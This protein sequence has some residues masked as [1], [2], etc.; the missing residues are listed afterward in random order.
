LVTDATA[1][2]GLGDGEFRLGAIPVDVVEGVAR[3]QGTS[4]I[5]GSTA[6]MDQLF[7]VAAGIG[8]DR[9]AA[10][11]AAVRLTS[12]TPTR[13]LGLHG[14]GSLRAGAA[15]NLVVLEQNL[16]VSAVMTHGDWQMDR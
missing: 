3:V 6:T 1:A 16:Q 12:T 15:A 2:A 8:S 10:L 5:A 4:T 13:A 11:A 9:D 14:V 7:R